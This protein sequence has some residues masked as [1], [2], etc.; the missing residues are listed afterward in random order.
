VSE[1][2]LL[3]EIISAFVS[4]FALSFV[5]TR[6]KLWCKIGMH[7]WQFLGFDVIR[8]VHGLHMGCTECR[9]TEFIEGKSP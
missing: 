5:F 8:G 6:W 9:Y 3:A 4:I 7:R 1:L 2:E